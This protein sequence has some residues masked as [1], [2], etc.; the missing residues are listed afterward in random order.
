MC[1][2]GRDE[3]NEDRTGKP[4]AGSE[5]SLKGDKRETMRKAVGEASKPKT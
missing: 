4:L 3:C 5:L 1:S 2:Q